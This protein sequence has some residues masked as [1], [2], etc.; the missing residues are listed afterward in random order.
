MSSRSRAAI[1]IWRGR[2]TRT[3]GDRAFLVYAVFMVGL[4]AIVPVARAVWLSATSA[5]GV[6]VFA[7]AAAPG[8]TAFVAVAL[9]AGALLL[10]RDRGPA[11]LP[12]FL[13]HALA[14]SDLP[15]SD[16]FRGPLLRAG[17]LVTALSMLAAG[18]IG[19]SLMSQ[20]LANPLSAAIF[21]AVGALVGVIT[22]VAWLAGQAF[23]RAAIPIALGLLALGAVTAIAHTLQPFTPWGWVGL[24]YPGND[25]PLAP[26]P[27]IAAAAAL[28]AVVPTLMNRLRLAELSSQA[29]R[30]ESATTHAMEMDFGAA[31]TIYQGRPHIGRGISAIR[32]TSRLPLTFLIRDAIGA[33]RTPGRLIVAITAFAAAGVLMF[34]A[35]APA[36]PSWVLG[37]AAGLLVFAGLGPLTDGMRHAASVASDLPL[38]GISDERLFANHSLFPTTVVAVVLL[39]A[40]IACSVL[41]GSGAAAPII[42]ALALGLLA[43][44]ARASNALKG[45]LPISLL[46]PAPTPMGDLSVLARMAWALDGVLLAALAGAFAAVAFES[47]ILLIGITVVIVGVGINRWRNRS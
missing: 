9:W 46:T 41:V 23:P 35:F 4:V 31:A 29:A 37:A 5:A 3:L 10:G 12:P 28:A 24:A 45:S 33:A 7:S 44:L 8:V 42:S 2:T 22:T 14:T 19:G 17:A 20:G 18:L 11:L 27:L 39:A 38:Y 36:T 15:Q 30:W 13:T 16:T 40:V 32:P 1:E 26:I 21:V 47:P 34:L 43:L 6:A 25:N